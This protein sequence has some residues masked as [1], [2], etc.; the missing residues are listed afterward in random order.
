MS[1]KPDIAEEAL[2]LTFREKSLWVQLVSIAGIYIY[3]FWKV[4]EIGDG[5][6]GRVAGL[7]IGVV[8]VMVVS[9]IV[10]HAAMA[11]HRRPEVLDER[12]QRIALAATRHAYYVLMTGAWCALTVCAMSVGTFWVAH[13]GLLAIVVAEITRCA[14]QLVHYRRGV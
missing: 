4:I 7:F 1:N 2:G 6:P 8:A 10:V 5:N 13:A 14:T 9:Q 11:I 12:D 3:Y